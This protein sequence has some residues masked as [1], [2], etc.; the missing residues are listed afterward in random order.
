MPFV[1][2]N[3]GSLKGLPFFAPF[4][5]ACFVLALRSELFQL[6]HALLTDLLVRWRLA[7]TGV[8]AEL[9]STGMVKHDAAA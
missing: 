6:P 2:G 9:S 3:P 7:A 5:Y 8:S 1:E 4:L